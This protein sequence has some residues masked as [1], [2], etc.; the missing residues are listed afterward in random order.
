MVPCFR[1]IET[2]ACQ[3]MCVWVE[4]VERN[5][6]WWRESKKKGIYSKNM[7]KMTLKTEHWIWNG[8][9]RRKAHAK[10]LT[11]NGCI[12]HCPIRDT[13][14]SI[15]L[16]FLFLCA[17]AVATAVHW[18]AKQ[19]IAIHFY[20]LWLLLFLCWVSENNNAHAHTQLFAQCECKAAAGRFCCCLLHKIAIWEIA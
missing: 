2:N 5:G 3:C 15:L 12:E 10:W 6:V 4:R 16:L 9:E 13:R 11:I 18:N 7:I 19:R 17:V 14:W 8:P 20:P 1:E